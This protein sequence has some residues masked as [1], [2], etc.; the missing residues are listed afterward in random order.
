MAED[1]SIAV[2]VERIANVQSTV[3]DIEKKLDN[4]GGNYV[5]LGIYNI[6]QS[7][8]A[9]YLKRVEK[10]LA[11]EITARQIADKA[12]A[13]LIA[14]LKQSIE[15]AKAQ[16]EKDRKQFW[17]SISVGGLLLVLGIFIQ[18]ITRALGLTP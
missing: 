17:T 16:R 1:P 15:D 8:T 5:P 9:E 10:A 4:F 14:L 6:N 12:N 2:L 13:D 18:P 7:N 3:S 11:D